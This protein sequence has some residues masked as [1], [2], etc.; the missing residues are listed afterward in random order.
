[1]AT[2]AQL[3]TCDGFTVEGPAGCLGWVEET[4]FDSDNHPAAVAIRTADGRRALLLAEAVQA[5]DP[6][7]QEVVVGADAELLALEP[8]RLASADGTIAATWQATD[9]HL[10]ATPAGAHAVPEAPALAAARAT[11]ATHERALWQTILFSLT[12]LAGLIAAEILLAFGIA[13]LVTG[14]PY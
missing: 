10:V 6:D 12:F 5:V 1:M 9:E 13:Y 14:H 8:P 4:W 2:I 3:Q 7:A 11:T